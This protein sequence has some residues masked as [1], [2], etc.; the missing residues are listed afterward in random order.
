LIGDRC[1]FARK[2]LVGDPNSSVSAISV[3]VVHRD[4]SVRLMFSLAA[5]VWDIFFGS[6]Q[7]KMHESP[8]TV[9]RC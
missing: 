2:S 5:M 4:S 9:T 8:E 3:V 7:T 6:L 1:V